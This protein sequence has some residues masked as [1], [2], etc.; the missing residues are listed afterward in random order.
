MVAGA[1]FAFLSLETLGVALILLVPFFI[2]ARR[3]AS[4]AALPI[5]AF[6]I[7]YVIAIGYFF[8]VTSGF[9]I[10]GRVDWVGAAFTGCFACV[11]LA[12]VMFGIV[13]GHHVIS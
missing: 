9:V 1:G 8:L 11:G 12:I 4:D 2:F 7:G 10:D 13:R 6:G 5:A 3:S